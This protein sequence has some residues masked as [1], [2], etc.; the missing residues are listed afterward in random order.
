[1]GRDDDIVINSVF[2]L[3]SKDAADLIRGLM[4]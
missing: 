2:Y 1:M 3:Q 4:P